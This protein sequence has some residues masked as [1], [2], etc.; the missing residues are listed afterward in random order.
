MSVPSVP[1]ITADP[2]IGSNTLTFAWT[3]PDE[4]GGSDIISYTLSDINNPSNTYSLQLTDSPFTVTGLT[5]GTPYTFQILATNDTGS[6]DPA[7]YNEATPIGPPSAPN[8]TADPTAGDGSLTFAWTAPTDDGGSE[9]LN[10]VLIDKNDPQNATNLDLSD[11]PYTLIGLTNGTGYE[12]DIFAVNS[13]GIGAS[14]NYNLG[15]PFTIPGDPGITADPTP[16]NGSLTFSWTAPTDNGGSVITS[17]TLSDV[18]NSG[19][20][21]NLQITDSPYKVTG[22]TNETAYTFQ[23]LATNDAGDGSIVTYNAGTPV[24]VAPE[25]PQLT[26]NPT[27]GNGS[28]TFAWTAPTDDGG[29]SITGYTLYDSNNT[30]TTVDLDITDSPYTFSGLSNG[31]SYTFA[32]YAINSIGNGAI[33]TYESKTPCTV[34]GAPVITATPIPGNGTLKFA[35]TAPTDNG[36]SAIISYSLYNPLGGT[37]TLQL[38]D[39]PYLVTGLTDG[40]PLIFEISANNVAGESSKATYNAASPTAIPPSA[41]NITADPTV[42]NK[43]LT[44]AWTAPSDNG[45]SNI[46]GYKLRSLFNSTTYTENSTYTVPSNMKILVSMWG[47]GGGTVGDVTGGSGAYIEG[48]LN[49]VTNDVLTI[50]VGSAGTNYGGIGSG[51]GLTSLLVNGTVVAVAGSGGGAGDQN[52]NGGVATAGPVSYCG[53][54][55]ANQTIGT[56]LNN[57]QNGGGA[58][59]VANGSE[60]REYGTRGGGG[61]GYYIGG[62]G[63]EQFNGNGSGGGGS[64][65]LGILQDTFNSRDGNGAVSGNTTSPFWINN[66]G[67]AGSPGLIVICRLTNLPN[68]LQ[69]SDSPYLVTGLTN[70]TSYLYQI[71]AMNSIGNGLIASYNS[72]TPAGSG[73]VPSAP[74]LNGANIRPIASDESLQIY[75][76]APLNDGGDDIIS[77]TYF[78]NMDYNVPHNISLPLSNSYII[79]S[80]TNG[81]EYTIEIAASNSVGRGPV[82]RYRTVQPG[83]KPLIPESISVTNPTSTSAVIS[84][85]APTD[86]GGATIKWYV[87]TPYSSDPADSFTA[88]DSS[89][90]ILDASYGHYGKR[91]ADG[92]DRSIVF[93]GLTEGNTYTFGVSA[94]NDPGYSP[95]RISIG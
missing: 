26:S 18:N 58:S 76:S 49:V 16:G 92:T 57:T 37:Y 74:Q 25:A 75:W 60:G 39:S 93:K 90:S 28:L 29:E 22:L 31:T 56:P 59:Q 70:G 35:W 3:V 30:Q 54:V 46:T 5:N 40:T 50:N 71:Y 47:A 81:T 9:I 67:N 80:L 38:S 85:T 83:N 20:S 41:P 12:F 63:G 32:I 7:A 79:T 48:T 78:I 91:S 88:Y 55:Y 51:G 82:A 77:Y 21:Y 87:I 42:G 86:D 52:Q 65:Y 14:A 34:P 13:V 15:T 84:W 24:T 10:Y 8:I 11:S 72:A 2:T 43:R 33:A 89:A 95:V 6:S 61:Q 62:N 66:A 53:G 69:I 68:T 23:I 44:F 94:V 17:Y 73:T 36:G 1:G 4:T 45:G 64:S 27:A 19:T